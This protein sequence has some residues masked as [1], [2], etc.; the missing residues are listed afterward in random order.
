MLLQAVN[1]FYRL[2]PDKENTVMKVATKPFSFIVVLFIIFP[3][4]FTRGP[5]VYM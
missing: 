3:F 4:I 1:F 2:P 5:T